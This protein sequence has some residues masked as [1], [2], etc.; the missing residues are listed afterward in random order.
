MESPF[1]KFN[2][3]LVKYREP[4]PVKKSSTIVKVVLEVSLQDLLKL[5]KDSNNTN[6]YVFYALYDFLNHKVRVHYDNI[7]RYFNDCGLAWES[8]K[9]QL[10]KTGE[11]IP[12]TILYYFRY[13]PENILIGKNKKL[14]L[15]E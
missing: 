8:L 9:D 10:E 12:D 13:N 3:V 1:K 5:G 6:Q 2:K 11:L 4:I 15:V 14:I 7:V